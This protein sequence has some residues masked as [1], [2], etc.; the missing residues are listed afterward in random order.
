MASLHTS[1]RNSNDNKREK[2]SSEK[3]NEEEEKNPDPNTM[4]KLAFISYTYIGFK[5]I[6]TDQTAVYYYIVSCI[7]EDN[8]LKIYAPGYYMQKVKNVHKTLRS[9]ILMFG[10]H[11]SPH[12]E[13]YYYSMMNSDS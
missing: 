5:V 12:A 3:E 7:W 6:S 11:Y 13:K 4:C 8:S 2:T 1:S 9:F 10:C